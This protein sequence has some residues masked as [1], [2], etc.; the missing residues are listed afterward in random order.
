MIPIRDEQSRVIAFGA[1]LLP[2]T[3]TTNTTAGM[4]ASTTTGISAAPPVSSKYDAKYVNSPG[5]AG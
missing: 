5:T 4:N 3:T 2:P 1:R